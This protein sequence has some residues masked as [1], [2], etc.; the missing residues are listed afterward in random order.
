[1]GVI[2]MKETIKDLRKLY[3]C[4]EKLPTTASE[5]VHN[6]RY[7]L[8]VVEKAIEQL[9]YTES[10]LEKLSFP[11][12]TGDKVFGGEIVGADWWDKTIMLKI[13]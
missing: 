6:V 9:A 10:E 13:E 11:V 8:P 7:C 4:I 1:M 2:T 3:D 12:T 5:E